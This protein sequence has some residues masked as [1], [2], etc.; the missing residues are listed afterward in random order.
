[1][2]QVS[3]DY[4]GKHKKF[5]TDS[6]KLA[7]VFLVSAFIVA[8]IVFWW[9]KLVGITVTGEAFCGLEEHTHTAECYAGDPICGYTYESKVTPSDIERAHIHTPECYEDGLICNKTEHSHTAECFPDKTADVETV[10]DWLSTFKKVE[11]TNNIPENLIGIAMSQMGYEESEKNFEYDSDGNKNGYTRYGEWYGN[12]YGKWNTMFVS[13]C[14]HYSNI[15]KD[16]EL[17]ASGAEAMRLAWEN[18][19]VYSPADEYTP[20]RGDIAFIDN[21][22][23]GTADA[24]AIIIAPGDT[25]YVVIMGDSNNRVETLSIDVSE[26]IIGY[27]H[28]SELH[29]AKDMEYETEA[30]EL[31]TEEKKTVMLNSP[32]LMQTGQTASKIDYLTDL[33]VFVSDVS[34]KTQNGDTITDGSTVYIGESYVVSLSFKEDDEGD[35]WHQFGHNDEHYLLYQLPENIYCEPTGWQPIFTRVEGGTIQNV[36]M[37]SIDENGLLRVTFIDDESGVCFG[38]R[39]SNVSFTIDFNAKISSVQSGTS[40]EVK[41]NEEIKVNLKVDGG[42]DMNVTKINGI[43]DHDDNTMEYTIKVEATKGVIKDLVVDDRIW[44]KHV[45]LKDTI[46][47][48]DLDGNLIDPQPAVSNN[49]NGSAGF[50]VTGFP[51]ISAGDGY[52]ITYKTKVNDELIGNKKIEYLW[53]EAWVS[54]KDSNDNK[55]EE[56]FKHESK[57]HLYRI[58][59]AGKQTVIDDSSGN[60]IPVIKWTVEI[61]KDKDDLGGTVIIDTLGDGLEYYTGKPIEIKREGLDENDKLYNVYIDWKDVSVENNEMSFTLPAGHAFEITYYTIYEPLSDE[62][63]KKVYNNEVHAYI[64]GRD[65]SDEGF[66]DVIGFSPVVT[67][68]ARGDDGKYVYYT[69]TAQVPA[70]IKNWGNFYLTDLLAIWGYYGP[71]K[72]MYIEN[73][74][75]D[76]EI[77]ATVGNDVITFTPYVEGGPTENT[78]ILMT[79]AQGEQYHSFNVY[80]NTSTPTAV[81]SKWILNQDAELTITYKIPFD[82]D[83][84]PEWTGPLTDE[85]KLEDVLLEK[86]TLYNEAYLNFTDLITGTASAPYIYTPKITKNSVANEDGTVDYTVTFYNSI[87]GSQGPLGYLTES[88]SIVFTDNFDEKLEYVPGSL[89][90]VTYSPWSDSTWFNKYVYK[91]TVTGNTIN[92]ESTA[93]EYEDT[94]QTL[95]EG[96]LSWLRDWMPNYQVYCNSVHGGRHVFTYK[97]KLKDKYL[98]TTDENKY[99]LDNTAELFWDEDNAS[100]PAT[101]TVEIRTGL[102]DKHVVQENNRLFFDI[103][104]N[105]NAL[106][107]LKG[108]ETITI[109]DTMTHNLSVYWDSI[110]LFYQDKTTGD[111]IDFDSETSLYKYTVTYDQTANRLTFVLPDE[112]HI[113]IDYT[114][115]IT[116]SGQVSVNNAVRVDG[117][118]QI[119]DFINAK[120]HVQDHSGGATGSIHNITLIKQDGDSDERLPG[121]SFY[122]YGPMGDPD[123]VLPDGVSK[124][125][126]ADNGKNLYYIGSY[127]TGEDGTVKIETQYLTLGGPY[128]L[129]EAAPP[130][131]Y[132]ALGKPVYFYFYEPDPDGI[133][134]T[135]TTL[136]AVEN[137]TYGF[138]LPETGGAGIFPLAIIGI[139]LMAYPVL[140][141]TIRRK[142]E[143]RLT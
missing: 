103:Y 107:I 70:I 111:W 87:P 141:S 64:D 113:R 138:V 119:T 89:S 72:P 9:L 51:D 76:M 75:L 90:V 99:V 16:S 29:F 17:K 92:V 126:V 86:R 46:V 61:V 105:R 112:L 7:T 142:R 4:L 37:Y 80:F 28:T 143:R 104:I 114:T 2:E 18:R 129:V 38:H 132:M 35:H 100:G 52:L 116:E 115:L 27:G 96:M 47:V 66:A 8:L 109:E 3:N 117:K 60:E 43:F 33:T 81:S 15:N 139:S 120:F 13:F 127:T 56:I 14:L 88:K 82:A 48:T 122:M 45:A 134:Q 39:Y 62:H 26:G 63:D 124:S 91:G 101:D 135:V 50:V 77:K 12:P 106:D 1:M 79:P 98:N 84:G 93:F 69:I 5:R 67:K 57:A 23:D 133:I 10:S 118:A 54:G 136:I 73:I 95:E 85:K 68:G 44:E 32:M 34:F 130:E 41:F 6:K 94:N 65:E 24:T 74:P 131:G 21:D 110:K 140:Y 137:Y 83:T 102:L 123:A 25:G 128:A 58:E 108:T 49:P 78:F 59:K 20:E 30:T 22:N 97:L 125:I 19:R 71:N 31:T 36:G 121:V 40:E 53:N 42:A 11:I 55:V